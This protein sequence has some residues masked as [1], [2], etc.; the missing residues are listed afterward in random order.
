MSL[1]C[2]IQKICVVVFF[3]ILFGNNFNLTEACMNGRTPVYLL[4]RFTFFSTLPQLL[5][6]FMCTH[7]RMLSYVHTLFLPLSVWHFLNQ[8]RV[9]CI[10]HGPKYFRVYFM[11]ILFYITTSYIVTNFS[12]SNIVLVPLSTFHLYSNFLS[13]PN[14]VFIACL[15]PL[16]QYHF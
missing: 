10:Y 4:S 5:Y 11:R 13:W 12:K 3:N 7:M 2:Y 16:E 9:S 6:Y 15:F 1:L 8:L 14:N